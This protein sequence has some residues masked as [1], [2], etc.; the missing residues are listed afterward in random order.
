MLP[1]GVAEV[2]GLAVVAEV[3]VVGAGAADVV[4]LAAATEPCT[5]LRDTSVGS[6]RP[7]S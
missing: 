6:T 5:E 2:T 7:S 4:G 1:G 3:A